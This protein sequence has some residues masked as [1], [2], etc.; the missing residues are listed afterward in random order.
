MQLRNTGIEIIGDAPWGTHFCQF[1]ETPRDLT[2]VLVPY[3][4]AGLEQGEFCMW[5][6]S[7]DLSHEEAAA[8]LRAAVPGFEAKRQQ[9]QIEILPHTEWYLKGGTFDLRRVLNGWVEKLEQAQAKGFAGLRLT[10]NTVWLEKKDWR[11]F[12]DYEHA[13]NQVIGEYRMMA[14]CT[15]SLRKCGALEILEVARNHQCRIAP[16]NR[17]A[18]A[19]GGGAARG[20]RTA[21]RGGQAPGQ[22]RPGAHG[23]AP[24]SHR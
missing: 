19:R 6:T 7:P 22:T 16:R 23:Q 12:A 3:F 9:G 21:R 13:V 15:Y 10:G 11:S 20:E 4:K 8:A 14:L 2:E 1:Y 24:G 5:V 18:Q 17:R